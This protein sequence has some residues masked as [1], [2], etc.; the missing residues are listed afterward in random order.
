M[1]T[2]RPL[3]DHTDRPDPLDRWVHCVC[4]LPCDRH[5]DDGPPLDVRSVDPN[6]CTMIGCGCPRCRPVDSDHP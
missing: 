5:P 6:A 1:T 3:D 2:R 4:P